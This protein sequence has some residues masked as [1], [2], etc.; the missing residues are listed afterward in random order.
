MQREAKLGKSTVA[1]ELRIWGDILPRPPSPQD[2]PQ[3]IRRNQSIGR[4]CMAPTEQQWGTP[5]RVGGS[6]IY[7][8]DLSLNRAL[9][10]VSGGT[11]DEFNIP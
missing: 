1:N 8:Q 6:S 5:V 10:R 3:S 11:G 9:R 2:H 7:K 4:D